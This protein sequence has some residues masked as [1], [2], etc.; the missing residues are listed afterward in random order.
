MEQLKR[1]DRWIESD[2]TDRDICPEHWLTRP[3][4]ICRVL[5]ELEKMEAKKEHGLV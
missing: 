5:A 2:P 4:S 1:L 3:C